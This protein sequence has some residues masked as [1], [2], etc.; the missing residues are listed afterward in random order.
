MGWVRIKG[1]GATGDVAIYTGPNINMDDAPLTN[2]LD[3]LSRLKFHSA[4]KYPKIKTDVAT[5]PLDLPARTTPNAALAAYKSEQGTYTQS[6]TLFKHNRA[7]MPWVLGSALVAGV[8]VGFCGSIPVQVDGPWARWLSI[9]A[10]ETHVRAFEYTVVDWE[11]A[12]KRSKANIPAI[13]I[14]IKLWIT[15]EILEGTDDSDKSVPSNVTIS[16]KPNRVIFNGGLFDSN[17][18]YLRK[19]A[20]GWLSTLLAGPSLAFSTDASMLNRISW[21][22]K[23]GAYTVA[24]P[25][26]AYNPAVPSTVSNTPTNFAL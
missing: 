16:I 9:G 19:V 20:S 17:F 8:N 7:G 25:S 26:S 13:T 3:N 1:R 22:F 14:P 24:S 10:D 23:C 21:R 12:R 18:R 15:D 11:K 5:I 6:Y 4:L 2:P